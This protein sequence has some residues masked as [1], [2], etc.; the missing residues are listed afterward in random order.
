MLNL[1][2]FIMWFGFDSVCGKNKKCKNKKKNIRIIRN[3]LVLLGLH[4]VFANNMF[5]TSSNSVFKIASQSEAI[6]GILHNVVIARIIILALFKL[7]IIC[8]FFFHFW[9]HRKTERPVY[10]YP[11]SSKTQTETHEGGK[12]LII[13]STLNYI[14]KNKTYFLTLLLLV[15]MVMLH[16]MPYCCVRLKPIECRAIKN[17]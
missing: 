12:T 17:N 16:C 9:L 2:H 11:V 8:F 5:S 15:K 13:R 10:K 7:R 3:Y 14:F 1:K 4:A 6:F